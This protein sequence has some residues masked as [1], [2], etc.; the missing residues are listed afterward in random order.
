MSPETSSNNTEYFSELKEM[1]PNYSSYITS[2]LGLKESETN[3]VTGR[4]HCFAGVDQLR[5]HRHRNHLDTS[6]LQTDLASSLHNLM[7]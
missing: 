2:L 1:S 6:Q 5:C 4:V 3:I 7:E